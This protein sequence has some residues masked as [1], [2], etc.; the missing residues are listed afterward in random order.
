[1]AVAFKVTAVCAK[2]LPFIFAPVFSEISVWLKMITKFPAVPRFTGA[3]PAA[4][5]AV[6]KLQTK[7][8]VRALPARSWPRR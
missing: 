2:A 5:A 8:L 1:M 3:G 4:A 6:V 7:S